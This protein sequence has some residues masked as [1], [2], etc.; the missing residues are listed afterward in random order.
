MKPLTDDAIDTIHTQKVLMRE[1]T[2]K[3]AVEYICAGFIYATNM[4]K[5]RLDGTGW[6]FGAGWDFHTAAE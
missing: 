4:R 6:D 2:P 5:E 1:H 3:D